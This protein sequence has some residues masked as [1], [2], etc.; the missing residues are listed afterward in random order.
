MNVFRS[1]IQLLFTIFILSVVSITPLANS[2]NDAPIYAIDQEKE[3]DDYKGQE[4]INNKWIPNNSK[5]YA[6]KYERIILR[7]VRRTSDIFQVNDIMTTVFGPS[8]ANI[9]LKN[10]N[11]L[12]CNPPQGAELSYALCYY[13]GPDVPTGQSNDNPSLP[14][15]LSPSGKTANCKCYKLSTEEIP[16][17]VP[18]F[19]DIH[20]ILN[21]DIYEQTVKACGHSGANCAPTTSIEAP[22]CSSINVN[23]LIPGAD[24]VSVYS[25]VKKLDYFPGSTSC[26]GLYAGCMTAPCYETGEKDAY[27]NKLVDCNCPIYVGRYEIG[28]GLSHGGDNQIQCHLPGRNIW[29]A[30]HNPRTNNPID[31]Q[32]P[33]GTCFPNTPPNTG[34]PLFTA[35]NDNVDPNSLMC[36]AVCDSYKQNSVVDR[37]QNGYTCDATLCTALGLGQDLPWMVN[38]GDRFRLIEKA[39]SGIRDFNNLSLI[40]QVE[41]L[42][43]CS[44]CASQICK[45]S[46]DNIN[47]KTNREILRLNIEQRAVGI[48]PQCDING[49]LCG[50]P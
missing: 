13:S 36:E 6:E 47:T 48:R 44:C 32:P 34:C 29:S 27:G 9:W 45:C 10:Q 1:A 19:V 17:N 50:A 46:E 16:P 42:A 2:E 11:F 18:Y 33:E 38:M 22:V 28:Q 25:P 5:W 4:I 3:F 41:T 24:M 31:P 43:G 39:C 30:A 35:G 8:W 7:G 26:R 20:A 49:T 14:C 12:K 15:T 21:K 23:Q 40:N 37:S